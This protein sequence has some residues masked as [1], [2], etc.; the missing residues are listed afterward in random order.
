[1]CVCVC[2]CVCVYM[3]VCV[4]VCVCVC[5]C[6]C[7]CVCVPSSGAVMTALYPTPCPTVSQLPHVCLFVNIL[8]HPPGHSNHVHHCGHVVLHLI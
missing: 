1:M 8:L 7:V 2:M 4:C 6:V 3:Y 5:M